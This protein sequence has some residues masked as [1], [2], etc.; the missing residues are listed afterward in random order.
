MIQIRRI[1]HPTDFSEGSEL[2]F[3]LAV[4]LAR[5]YG[6]KL[7]LL[8]VGHPPVTALGAPTL[9][10]PLAEE[11]NRPDLEE[12]LRKLKPKGLKAEPEYRLAIAESASNEIVRVAKE[13]GCDVV[14]LGT[15]GRTGLMRLLLGSVAEHV[16]RN[17]PCSVLTVKAPVTI[18][19][20]RPPVKSIASR[21]EIVS[22]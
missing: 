3:E 7:T 19:D 14:V 11:W 12:A 2:A 16:V 17:A 4:A 5:D 8:H 6:A 9:E 15:H 10:P 18:A 20:D 13:I 21:T 22:G 1:L